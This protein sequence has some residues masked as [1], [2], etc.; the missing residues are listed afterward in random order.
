M[1][2]EAFRRLLLEQKAS[3]QNASPNRST[4]SQPNS[5]PSAL[6]TKRT[7]LIPMTPRTVRGSTSNPLDFA[8]Q[9]AAHNAASSA[10]VQTR[11][12][13]S[14]AAPKGVRLGAGYQDRTLAR[15]DY[16]DDERGARILA[17]EEQ[18]KLGQ[19]DQSTFEALRDQITG[20]D[21]S[22]THLVKGLDRKLL[23]RVRRGEDVLNSEGKA[24]EVEDVD[25]DGEFEALEEKEVERVEREKSE[26][27]GERAQT[28]AVAG[29]KRSRDQILAELKAQRKAEAEKRLA[30]RPE[31]GSAFRDI[32]AKQKAATRIERDEKGREVMITVDEHGN[33]KKKVRKVQEDAFKAPVAADTVKAVKFLDEGITLPTL[34]EQKKEVIQ[35]DS[36]DEGDIFGDVGTDYNPLGDAASSDDDTSDEDGE[37][38]TTKSQNPGP[39]Q[40]APKS[41]TSESKDKAA[42]PPP[43]LPQATKQEKPFIPRNY[44]KTSAPD[45][46]TDDTTPQNP[47]NDT[48]FLAAIKK[49]SALSNVSFSLSAN[50]NDDND[51]G[52]DEA[53]KKA[54][55]EARARK[56]AAMLANN[57]RDFEDMDMGFGS[58]RGAD[59]EDAEE[60]GSKV[61]LSEWKGMVGGGEDD[62]EDGEGGKGGGEKKKRNRKRKGDKNSAKDVLGVLE[63][64]KEGGK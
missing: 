53:A 50:D 38:E 34:K 10:P 3:K 19:L 32:G 37:V 6:G 48:N 44:F 22:A 5:T 47:F 27:K 23:E 21:I 1:N 28:V 58:S 7:S 31:L 36:E 61:K 15:K 54:A 25:V 55:Q 14:S 8:R 60:G 12:P 40:P 11:K 4:P 63:R 35:E 13:K 16:S 59:D 41:P 17:L 18:M 39:E 2:N 26:K 64:R 62:E 49:A 57:D 52:S 20:G 24:E 43:P 56:H 45:P 33:V 29:A 9:F 51:D 42:M 30:A 46:T